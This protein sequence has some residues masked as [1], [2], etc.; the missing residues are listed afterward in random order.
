[1]NDKIVEYVKKLDG[2]TYS[3]WL[4]LYYVINRVFDSKK[5]ELEDTIKLSSDDEAV[6]RALSV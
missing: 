6:T 4:K 2:I 5:R 3:E 1:M